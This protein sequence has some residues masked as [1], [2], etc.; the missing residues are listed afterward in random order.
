M[1]FG[2]LKI[3]FFASP[4]P[5]LPI[6]IGRRGFEYGRL[7]MPIAVNWRKRETLTSLSFWRGPG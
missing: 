5:L 7:S 1:F 6:A 4:Y 3:K 2:C